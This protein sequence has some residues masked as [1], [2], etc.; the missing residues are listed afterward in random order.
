M[1]FQGAINFYTAFCLFIGLFGSSFQFGWYV[2]IFNNPFQAI[3]AFYGQ[4]YVSR[5]NQT[6]PDDA[7][8]T[9]W[10]ITNAMNPLGAIFGALVSGIIADKLGR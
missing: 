2:S 5:Y 8:T 3:K 10:S 6:M 9:L 4:V 1:S 7:F